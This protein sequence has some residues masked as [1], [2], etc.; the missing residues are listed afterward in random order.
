MR[1]VVVFGQVARGGAF[2]GVNNITVLFFLFH[3]LNMEPVVK[4]VFS[5]EEADDIFEYLKTKNFEYHKPYKRY[6]KIVK[7][8]RG[9]A[10]YTLDETIH[11]NY[12]KTAG[13]SPPN[14]VMD[15][16]MKS[17]TRKVNEVLGA[18]YNTILMNVY[19]DGNDAIGGHQDNENGWAPNT[20]FATIAFG[21]ERPFV[22][23]KIDTKGRTRIRH[24]N[25]MVIEMPYPMNHHFLHGVP[26][27]SNK[28]AT[29][30]RIS[31]TL[32]EII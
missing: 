10:S 1:G 2:V 32:R 3:N 30:W 13:G 27:C 6:N 24:Q 18:N 11:Y 5:E 23:E 28:V 17:I 19:K 31:L 8:P 16:R 14:E 4:Q 12:G 29:K 21:C 22:I 20:G 25:G 7:V 15:E 26:I 9:Q